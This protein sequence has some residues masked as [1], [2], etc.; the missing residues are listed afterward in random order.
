MH[1]LYFLNICYGNALG[2]DINRFKG[3][4]KAFIDAGAQ[5]VIALFGSINTHVSRIVAEKFYREELL[6][7]KNHNR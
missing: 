5:A 1:H 6:K 7:G 4:G 3:L 2:F